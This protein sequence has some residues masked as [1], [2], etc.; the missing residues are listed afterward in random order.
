MICFGIQGDNKDT[1]QV[2]WL[3]W[4]LTV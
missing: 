4:K 2:W 3:T 1:C